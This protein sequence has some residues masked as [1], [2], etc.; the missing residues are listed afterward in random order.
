[1]T[2]SNYLHS[3]IYTL[4]QMPRPDVL[5]NTLQYRP[6]MLEQRPRHSPVQ[7]EAE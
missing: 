5:T 4:C 3:P 7:S 2:D 1:M 6:I